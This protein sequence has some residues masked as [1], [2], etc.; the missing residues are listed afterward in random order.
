M[1]GKGIIGFVLVAVLLF[2]F[3]GCGEP[4][5]FS[6][7]N[8]TI[9]PAEV[10][11]DEQVTISVLVANTGGSQGSYDVV[12][13]ING[14]EEDTKSVTLDAGDSDN[15]TFNVSRGDVGTYAVTIEDLSGSFTVMLPLSIKI[16][17]TSSTWREGAPYDIYSAIEEKVASVGI[18]V[19]SDAE[20]PYD[21]IL[22]VEYSETEGDRYNIGTG[23]DINCKLELRDSKGKLLF[24]TTLF[25]RTGVTVILH[26]GE[27]L[28]SKALDDFKREIYF[29]YLGEIIAAKFGVGDEVLIIISALNEEYSVRLNA[30]NILGELGDA[31][32]AEPLI[33]V[34]TEEPDDYLRSLAAVA[35]GKIRDA[36]AVEPLIQAL[37]ED[38]SGSV[39]GASAGALGAIGDARAVEPLI[40][41]LLEDES[42]GVRS[43]AA[44]ALGAIGDARA[45]EA[46]TQAL[47]DESASVRIAA[48]DALEKIQGG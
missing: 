5:A 42:S 15:V 29:K 44:K 18:K 45:V 27:S 1:K 4:A 28:Y 33:Q 41:A 48:E 26:T 39:R 34:L 24:E 20:E 14:T 36:A 23:T 35:L 46:L 17:V 19:V 6:L 7:S 21:A 11:P 8:L 40:Q 47:D 2:T 32:A 16:E 3:A 13:E 25:G 22:N 38:E 12:L 10:L 31:R 37:L 43:N 30:I 9:E